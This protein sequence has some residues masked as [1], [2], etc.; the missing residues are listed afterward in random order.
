MVYDISTNSEF[1]G[2]NTWT[3]LGINLKFNLREDVKIMIGYSLSENKSITGS[4]SSLILDSQS[5]DN[6]EINND[7]V[8]L[9]LIYTLND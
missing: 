4:N 2:L 9:S 1:D 8:R 3:D 5:V 7:S 6:V